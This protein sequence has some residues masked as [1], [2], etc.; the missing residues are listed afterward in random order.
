MASPAKAKIETE[1]E[2]MLATLHE[3]LKPGD[4]VHT[5]LD[6]VSRSGMSRD[7]RVIVLGASA[8]DIWHPNYAVRTVLGYPRA[9]HGDGLRVGGCGMDIGFSVVYNLSRAMFPDGFECVGDKCP[10]NDHFNGD[11]N[12]KPHRHADGGYAL[13]HRWL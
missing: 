4:T 10:S 2:R 13:R 1:R 6:H 12:H 5:I 3:H 7:I 9:K 11:R 8:D